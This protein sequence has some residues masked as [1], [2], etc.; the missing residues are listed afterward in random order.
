LAKQTAESANRAK[1]DF[2][3]RMSHEIRTPMNL[4]M[5]M[6]ALLLESEL[7]EK[8]RKHVTIS[9][10]NVRRLLRLINGILDLSKV[11]AGKLTLEAV[12][13]DLN[14]TFAEAVATISTA[15]EQKGLQ[16]NSFVDP[17][18]WPY[19]VGDPERLQQVLL[20][21]VGNAVKFTAKGRIELRV[22]PARD[23]NGME[24][25]RFEVSDTGCGVPPEQA[26]LI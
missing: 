17:A 10:R 7:T 5:G 24:G 19:W 12:P 23:P 21:L 26:S 25:V 2:L 20:N 15:V 13:F 3:A 18:V 22:G 11:E 1:S 4:I 8:Q 16:L 6:N 14:E 9:Y